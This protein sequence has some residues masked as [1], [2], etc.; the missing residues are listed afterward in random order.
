MCKQVIREA[1]VGGLSGLAVVIGYIIVRS[2]TDG[3]QAGDWLQFAGAM[4][5][6][7]GAVAGALFIESWKRKRDNE[8]GKATMLDV[9]KQMDESFKDVAEPLA[10][11]VNRAISEINARRFFLETTKGYA[12]FVL[13]QHLIPNSKVWRHTN[14]LINY[15]DRILA[16]TWYDHDENAQDDLCDDKSVARWHK[17]VEKIAGYGQRAA[18]L[19][20]EKQSD[21]GKKATDQKAEPAAQNDG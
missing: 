21:E 19:V 3:A 16:V 1:A 4:L 17:S 6:T 15:I 10:D 20:I 8:Q 13:K 18:K 5:G 11:D 12:E 14:G 7:G 9:L 2:Y